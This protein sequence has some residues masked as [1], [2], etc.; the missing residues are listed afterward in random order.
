MSNKYCGCDN[1]S[2]PEYG[3]PEYNGYVDHDKLQAWIQAQIQEQI[4]AQIQAQLQAQAQDQDQD[5]DQKT[6]FRGVGNSN[7]HVH[8]D[9]D[10]IAVA[11]LVAVGILTGAV[12]GD[13]LRSYIAAMKKE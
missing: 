3:E 6:V 11:V 5:Q 13:T 10:F 9:N 12:D 2:Y 4:Q 8:V 1:G 7:V